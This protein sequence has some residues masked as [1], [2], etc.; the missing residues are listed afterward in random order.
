MYDSFTYNNDI[1]ILKV[2]NSFIYSQK[3]APISVCVSN[4]ELPDGASLTITGWGHTQFRGNYSN[5]LQAT[6][7]RKG[8]THECNITYAGRITDKMICVYQISADVPQGTCQVRLPSGARTCGRAAQ[9]GDSGGPL[10][11]AGILVGVVSFAKGCA[12]K[13]YPTVYTKV[14]A[15]HHW[16]EAKLEFMAA[17]A[18]ASG[19]IY[20]GSRSA[21]KQWVWNGVKL[22]L[23]MKNE[24]P[25]E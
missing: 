17:D 18:E 3:V 23:V 6:V 24:E 21:L 13:N 14:S 19:L 5:Q 20:G 7:L 10:T 25:L 2:K 12:Y 9:G 16:I 11:Y 1:S 4:R 8:P 22:S 15:F